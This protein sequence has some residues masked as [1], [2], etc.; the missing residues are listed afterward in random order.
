MFEFVERVSENDEVVARGTLLVCGDGEV[1]LLVTA[2][3]KDEVEAV[4]LVTVVFFLLGVNAATDVIAEEFFGAQSVLR[5]LHIGMLA[6]IIGF[7]LKSKTVKF[8]RNLSCDGIDFMS[9]HRK[10]NVPIKLFSC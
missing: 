1:A 6:Q 10:S 7:C 4:L 3:S 5:F 2:K 8:W 9:F